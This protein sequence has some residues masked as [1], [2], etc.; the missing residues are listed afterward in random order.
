MK[1]VIGIVGLPLAGK[2]T[3][4]DAI[5]ALLREDAFT[6]SRHRFSDVLRDTLDLWNLPHGRTNEQLLAQIME[7][8]GRGTLSRAVGNR[9]AKDASDVGILDGVRWLSDEEMIRNF[10]ERGT[11][12]LMLCVDADADVRYGRVRTRNRAGEASLT[13]REFDHE[14]KAENEVHI[15]TIGAR[16]D[17]RLENNYANIK[18]FQKNVEGVYRNSIRRL[19]D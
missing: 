19:L 17:F 16:A 5:A 11:K 12:S 18:D 15:A 7:R 6:V 10:A 13:R 9:I 14:E 8:F 4:A 1:L 3:A 2:E